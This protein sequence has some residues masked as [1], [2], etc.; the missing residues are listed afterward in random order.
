MRQASRDDTPLP[1]QEKFRR[2]LDVRDRYRKF[3]IASLRQH[4]VDDAQMI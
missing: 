2:A 1:R 3:T 4:I